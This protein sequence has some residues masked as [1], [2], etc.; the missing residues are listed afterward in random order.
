MPALI[1]AADIVRELGGDPEGT[2]EQNLRLLSN[3]ILI[4]RERIK[5][6]EDAEARADRRAG[7]ANAL[8]EAAEARAQKAE[9]ALAE[10]DAAVAQAKR[11]A[12]AGGTPLH[13]PEAPDVRSH[14]VPPLPRP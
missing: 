9:E 10:I 13:I 2:E 14:R 6:A 11:D 4:Q 5:Q 12:V 7:R 8:R 3:E 1:G